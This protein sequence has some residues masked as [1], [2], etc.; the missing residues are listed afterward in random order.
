M[1]LEGSRLVLRS[2]LQYSSTEHN[3]SMK[4]QHDK[5]SWSP[6]RSGPKQNYH[7]VMP[8]HRFLKKENI[9]QTTK[10]PRPFP[11]RFKMINMSDSCHF[12]TYR[13]ASF[14]SFY[15]IDKNF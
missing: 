7:T 9:D 1:L 2:N 10:I 5:A 13:L 4:H 11:P 12:I 15:Y 8:E 3:N 6:Y 14:H